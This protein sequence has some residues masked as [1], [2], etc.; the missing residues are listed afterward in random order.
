MMYTPLARGRGA[1]PRPP[2]R[3]LASATSWPACAGEIDEISLG[4]GGVGMS[5]AASLST[6]AATRSGPG[7]RGR[8]RAVGTPVR[9]Q[10]S[11]TRSLAQDHQ[12]LDQAVRLGLLDRSGP[13]RRRRRSRT[14][15]PA[16]WS[17][18]RARSRGGRR[19][20][21]PQRGGR[22]RAA[23]RPAPRGPR[24][25]RSTRRAGRRRA[26]R[27]SGSG[28][29]R[30]SPSAVGRRRRSG[31]RSSPRA[32]RP[33]GRGCRRRPRA[34][35]AAS[36]RPSRGRRRC[37]RVAPPR[38]RG[39]SRDARGRRRRRC[40]SRPGSP[41]AS[42]DGRD[43]VVEV[44]R[45]RRVDGEGV[46]R[47][48]VAPLR[49]GGERVGGGVRGF[50]LEPAAEAA[51][52]E[53]LPDQRRGDVAGHAGVAELGDH[54]RAG[55]VR[56]RRQPAPRRAPGP[57]RRSR[58]ARRRARTTARR[59]GSG[60]GG[61]PRRRSGSIA[62]GRQLLADD[63]ERPVERLVVRLGAGVVGDPDVGLDALAEDR[64][65]VRGQVLADRQVEGAA[66]SR[67]P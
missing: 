56:L 38:G 7:A 62:R 36:A 31:S 39:P 27:P 61:R 50:V 5:S 67:G 52:A 43:R 15:T 65:A 2:T 54:A 4:S 18:S 32:G 57:H 42:S 10:C 59:R 29:G 48:Q 37:C 13:R 35:A 47:G 20:A 24:D 49:V 60:R 9:S 51:L 66:G 11:A 44:A 22:A 8:G 63:L 55:A 26:A 17:R 1:R 25:R 3:R 45:G 14:R 28:C 58:P 21:S 41:S 16:R 19:A 34:A 23:R 53:A 33:R 40:G 46:E 30:S 6:S 64:G 12:L